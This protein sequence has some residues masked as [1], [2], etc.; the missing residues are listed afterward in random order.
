MG[1]GLHAEDAGVIEALVACRCRQLSAHFVDVLVCVAQFAAGPVVFD[2]QALAHLQ[3]R[4]GGA[5]RS[6][7]W[8]LRVI[9]GVDS[10]I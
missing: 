6:R 4:A 10:T 5:T 1:R 3:A 9:D 7:G 2:A 8:E